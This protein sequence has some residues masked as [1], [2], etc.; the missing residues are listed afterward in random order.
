M[1]S[2][3]VRKGKRGER[4]AAALLRDLLGHDVQRRV[5]QHEGDSDLLGVPG[6]GLEVKNCAQLDLPAWWR[7]CCEQAGES[8]P[9]LLYKI[10]RRGWRVR[11]PLAALLTDQRGEAMWRGIEWTADTTVEAWAA[12]V[13]EVQK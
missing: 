2:A 7:Q 1:S 4:E 5:R 3:G 13:R 8:I 10:P 9:A 6:W 11:W 12:V